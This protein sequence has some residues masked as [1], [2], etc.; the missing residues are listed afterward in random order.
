VEQPG[1][2]DAAAPPNLR[3]VRQIELVAA[4]FRHRR[5]IDVAQDVEA[6]GIGLHQPVFDAVMHHLD[7][8]PGPGRTTIDVALLDPLVA[9]LAARRALD[10]ADPRCQCGEDRAEV[11][12]RVLVAADHHAIAAFQPPDAAAAAD[13]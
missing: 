7:E 10:R 3:Y 11:I 13:I 5:R 2:N 9:A 12:G 1:G 4:V 6:L 8:M